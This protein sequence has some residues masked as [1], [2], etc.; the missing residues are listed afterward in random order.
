LNSDFT[1][2]TVKTLR[3]ISLRDAKKTREIPENTTTTLASVQLNGEEFN[4]EGI[5]GEQKRTTAIQS[6]IE[7]LQNLLK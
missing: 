2:I 1:T 3:N 6:L 7:K 5:E 4:V